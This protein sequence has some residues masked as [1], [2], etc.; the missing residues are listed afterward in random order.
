[1]VSVTIT[2]T[3]AAIVTVLFS[4]VWLGLCSEYFLIVML[5][6]LM[7]M[8]IGTTVIFMLIPKVITFIFSR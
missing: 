4:A 8:I 6:I 1:M 5:I 3:V 7:V 2:V